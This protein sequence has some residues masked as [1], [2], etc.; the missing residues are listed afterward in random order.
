MPADPKIKQNRHPI[1]KIATGIR[2]LDEILEGGFPAGRLTL[3]AGGPGT[4]KTVLVTEFLYQGAQDGDPG[5]LVSFE[6]RAE[7]I[8]T[9]ARAMGW[10]LEALE[11]G[12][13]LRIVHADLPHGTQRSGEFTLNGLLAMLDGYTKSL[14]IQR[15]VLD[16]L[17]VLIRFFR[18]PEKEQDQFDLL[19]RWL[20]GKEAAVILTA[21]ISR[22]NQPLYHSLEYMADC[23]LQLDQRVDQQVSTRRLR[24]IKYRGSGYLSNEHPYLITSGGLVFLPVSSIEL[25]YPASGDP[26]GSG[27]SVLDEILGGG[28]R[29][30]AC[31]L[32]AGS[33]GTGKTTLA[34]MF[35]K[36]ACDA[37]EKVL[38]VNLEESENAMVRAMLNTSLDLRPDL[39]SGNLKILSL[40]PESGGT[41]E[42]LLRI[43]DALNAYGARY[44]IVDAISACRRMGSKGAVFDFLVRLINKCRKEGVILLY[45]NQVLGME[46]VERI[47]GLGVSSLADVIVFLRF[48]ETKEGLRRRLLVLKARGQSHSHL[49]HEMLIGEHGVKI[50]KI[51]NKD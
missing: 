7:D 31:I 20:Q 35:A 17:D 41:E 34:S 8:R 23:V 5:L 39:E 24:V 45:T 42:H 21:K 46:S 43:L 44:M 32:M 33:T 27:H 28:Y 29:R 19:H 1:S 51:S 47:S 16:A 36:C 2:G 15:I 4:G 38:Y 11:A 48:V 25:D 9:N 13:K 37:G 50:R 30:G 26:I 12:S 49:Y 40:M 3:V 22:E 6:E 10:D 18:D 14:G